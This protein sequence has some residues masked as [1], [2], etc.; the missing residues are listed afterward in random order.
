MPGPGPSTKFLAA[1][2]ENL[3]PIILRA[4]GEVNPIRGASLLLDEFIKRPAVFVSRI[5]QEP[6][7]AYHLF[8]SIAM[9]IYRAARQMIAPFRPSAL[10]ID[11][12]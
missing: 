8:R 11:L 12:L 3:P 5:E 7:I 6:R 2:E 1:V 9:D 4:H 10:P